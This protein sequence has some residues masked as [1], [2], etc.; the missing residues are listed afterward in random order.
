LQRD[1]Q[2]RT[3]QAIVDLALAADPTAEGIDAHE[4]SVALHRYRRM[5]VVESAKA[6]DGRTRALKWRWIGEGKA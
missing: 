2:W 1:G 4:V 6:A 3:S 5:G